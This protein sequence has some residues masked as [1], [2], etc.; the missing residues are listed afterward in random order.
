MKHPATVAFVT[1]ALL[2]VLNS[3]ALWALPAHGGTAP[4]AV[5]P[6]NTPIVSR[7][8][9]VSLSWEQSGGFAGLI[10]SLKVEG[11]MFSY[12]SGAREVP[13][14]HTGNFIEHPIIP[15]IQ[16][17]SNH[18]LDTLI[19][20]LN[21]TRIPA[22]VGNY[23]QP[24]LADGFQEV[25]VLTISDKNDQ[26]QQFTIQNYGNKAPRGYLEFM[27]FFRVLA[28][29]KFPNSPFGLLPK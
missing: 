8:N 20:K 10:T 26:D 15:Q 24:N 2:P 25:L 9:F 18:Q 19:F 23:R 3:R 5:K 29:K 13:G 4:R 14:G 11:N 6:Q 28:G 16:A 17:M 22:L 12:S 27:T 1:L 21:Q 7:E